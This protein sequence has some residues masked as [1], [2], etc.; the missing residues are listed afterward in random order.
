MRNWLIQACIVFVAYLIAGRLAQASAARSISVG[1]LWPAYGIALAAILRGGNRMIPAVAASALLVSLHNPIPI[2]VAIGQALSTTFSACCGSW[3]LRQLSFDNALSRPRDILNLVLLGALISAMMSASLGVATL[4]VGGIQPYASI[5]HAW[6]VYWMG[7]GTGV[8]LAT[9]L[10]LAVG[11]PRFHFALASSAEYVALNILLLLSCF[12]IF[13]FVP[14]DVNGDCLTF[15]MLPFVMLIAVRFGLLGASLSTILVVAVAAVATSHGQGPFARSE[16]FTNAALLDIFYAVVSLTG[17]TLAALMAQR[18]QAQSER[19]NLVRRQAVAK[20]QEETHK[21]NSEL[22]NQLAHLGRIGMVNTLSGALAHEINQPLAA[23][24]INAESAKVFLTRQPVLIEHANEALNEILIDGERANEVLKHAR[25]FLKK[26]TTAR[27]EMDLNSAV[28][29]VVRLMHPSALKRGVQLDIQLGTPV[30]PTWADRVQIQQV[31]ANLLMNAFE[32]LEQ[33]DKSLRHVRLTTEFSTDKATVTVTDN[34]PHISDQQMPQ[35]F[36]AFYTSKP[37]GMGLG[38]TICRSIV[39]A[40]H[41]QLTAHRNPDG[42]LSFV[43]SMPLL[44]RAE[45]S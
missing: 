9:P 27:E 42:G 13:G 23:I 21:Q 7:D 36:D 12:L 45:F 3:L 44:G 2:S 31:V 39:H 15:S 40:H 5:T 33:N 18:A 34:G 38:L 30:K 43:V 28:A 24:R 14:L 4:Y 10:A 26:A 25:L 16:S 19:D 32:A 41:G 29:D 1:P 37:D 20:A 35:L 8:L 17:I 11:R 6:L 22:Q